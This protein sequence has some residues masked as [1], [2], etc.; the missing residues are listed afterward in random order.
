MAKEPKHFSQEDIF[1]AF[2]GALFVGL[3]FVFRSLVIDIAKTISMQHV[4]A[5]VITAAILITIEIYYFGY[6]RIPDRERPQ[7][8]FAEFWAKRFI[9]VYVVSL[10]TSLFLIYLYGLNYLLGDSFTILKAVVAISLPC[11]LAAA[12]TD[13]FR[14]IKF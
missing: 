7:R 10:L 12:L 14:K 13:L 2:L 9:T 4:V 8:T 6:K 5:L 1:Y 3:P 11:S